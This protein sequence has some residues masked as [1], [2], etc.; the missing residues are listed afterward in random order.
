MSNQTITYLDILESAKQD[1]KSA[2]RNKGVTPTGGYAS[3]ADAITSIEIPIIEDNKA[4]TI[5]ENGTQTIV[6]D[7]GYDAMNSVDVVVDVDIPVFETQT[8]TIP[9]TENGS[10]TI[11]PDS[12]YDGLSEVVVDV[13][14][15]PDL[16]SKTIPITENGSKTISYDENYDGL[17]EV[18]VEVDVPIPTYVSQSKSITIKKNGSQT[19]SPDSG[20]DGL[21][22]VEI[23]VEVSG[24]GGGGTGKPQIPN[25]FRFT[26]GD[27]AQVD[28]GAYDWSMVYDMKQFFSGCT[29]STGDWS[30]F[31]ENFN[32]KCLNGYQISGTKLSTLPQSL[33]TTGMVDASY[34]F[35]S[36]DLITSIPMIDT[37]EVATTEGMFQYCKKLTTIPPIDTSKSTNMYYMFYQCNSLTS[38]PQLDYSN[39]TTMEKF[40]NYAGGVGDLYINAP[41]CTTMADFYREVSSGTKGGSVVIDA[42]E[43][44][45]LSYAFTGNSVVKHISLNCPKLSLWAV[46]DDCTSLESVEFRMSLSHATN[47]GKLFLGARSLKSI[48]DLDIKNVTKF[49]GSSQTSTNAWLSGNSALESIGVIDCDSIDDVIYMFSS[50]MNSL[51]HLGGFRNLGKSETLSNTAYSHFSYLPNLTY[52]SVIN[53]LNGLYD[54]ASAGYS[55]LTLKLHANHIA[56]LSDADIAIATN[57]GWSLTS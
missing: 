28:F 10:Q 39:V 57:K 3:Y 1:I 21:S 2:L 7:T 45:N 24:G 54:R 4:I 32:G 34:M 8:K 22:E 23:T 29:H 31:E 38:L 35:A 48:P 42:P 5:T 41:K 11:T 36:N 17:S 44:T 19:V 30:N 43:L 56:M 50:T 9:I 55:V 15:T 53:V 52:E 33:D 6:P 46:F 14:V 13:E 49:Y 40:L 20:Y 27:L 16:Q 26:E 25:G 51:K 12:G 37:S 47:I 18:V